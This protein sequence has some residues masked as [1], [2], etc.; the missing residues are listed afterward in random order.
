M[1]D[2]LSHTLAWINGNIKHLKDLSVSAEDASLEHGLGL[3]ESMRANQGHIPLFSKHLHRL[4]CSAIELRLRLD[5]AKLPD[6]DE[7][8]ELLAKAGLANDQAR[9]RMV[10][11]G[12]CAGEPGQLWV[13]AHPLGDYPLDRLSLST[14]FW[15]VDDRDELIRYKTLNYWNRRRAFERAFS[16]NCHEMLSQD[17]KGNIWESSRSALFLVRNGQLIAPEAN[18]PKLASIAA[19][20]VAEIASEVHIPIEYMR[21]SSDELALADEVILANA[22]RG[23]MTVGQFRDRKYQAPGPISTSLRNHWQDRYF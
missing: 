6:P 18:G 3:F 2:S 23:L 11:T 8:R 4:K 19:D 15:P 12:G 17:T 16:Q 7:M 22:V 13:S 9:L 10:L 14:D 5:V 20:V 21:I 1:P